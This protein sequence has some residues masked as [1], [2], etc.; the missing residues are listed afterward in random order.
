M[1]FSL[2]RASDKIQIVHGNLLHNGEIRKTTE[3]LVAPGQ[4]GFM[5]GWGVFSTLRVTDGILFAWERHFRR[6]QRDAERMH[7]PFLQSSA[8][9]K[10]DLMKLV[11]ANMALHATLRVAIIRNRGGLFE[12]PELTRDAD[13]VA[14]TTDLNDWGAGVRLS[15]IPNARFAASPFAGTKYTS[16]SENLTFNEIAHQRGFDELILLNE[17]GQVSECTSA[18]IFAMRGDKIW[19]PPLST[20]GCLAGVTRALLLEE[21][22]IPGVEICERELSPSELEACEAVFIT[23]TTR[24]VLPVLSIDGRAV[25][26]EPERLRAVQDEFARLQARYVAEEP[27]RNQTFAA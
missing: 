9:L 12:A 4:V 6:M 8:E 3:A 17:H 10:R 19:T 20:A 11:S 24:D 2:R 15:Y 27:R 13:V 18:N 1:R 14:F 22:R 7:V 25:K 21:V 5:N 26:Q 23:S 16:W